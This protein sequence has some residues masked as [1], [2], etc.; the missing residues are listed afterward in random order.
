M[1][2]LEHVVWSFSVGKVKIPSPKILAPG[3]ALVTLE[4]GLLLEVDVRAREAGV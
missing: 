4:N 3:G 1:P 2:E